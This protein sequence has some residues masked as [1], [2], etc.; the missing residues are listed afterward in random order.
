MGW[1]VLFEACSACDILAHVRSQRMKNGATLASVM[2]YMALQTEGPDGSYPLLPA[3]IH[4]V[5]RNHTDMS[6]FSVCDEAG[7]SP[8]STAVR[9]RL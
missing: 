4:S 1:Q 3:L 8:L 5:A 9:V 6:F 7:V 2:A